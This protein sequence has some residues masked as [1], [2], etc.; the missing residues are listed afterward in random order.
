M[1][2]VAR[3]FANTLFFLQHQITWY[4]IPVGKASCSGTAL[5]KVLVLFAT[6]AK[7]LNTPSL[8]TECLKVV[9]EFLGNSTL[10]CVDV[11]IVDDDEVE[12]AEELEIELL[13]DT[14]AVQK[15]ENAVVTIVDN[16][17]NIL[18]NTIELQE[19]EYTVS[20]TLKVCVELERGNPGP[21]SGVLEY[22]DITTT[23]GEGMRLMFNG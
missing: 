15:T 8:P 21:V 10:E 9:V 3:T 23:A 5:E 7:R 19:V 20:A 11:S 22:H 16:D 2:C 6:N 1:M 12:E 18:P 14:A 13:S 17:E 4:Y